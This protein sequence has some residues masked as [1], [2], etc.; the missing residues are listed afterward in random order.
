MF[1]VS[2]L[3]VLDSK[4]EVLDSKLEALDSNLDTR[5][6]RV[7]RI[8][9]RVESFE[10][11]GTVN[12]HLPGTVIQGLRAW[13][14][15]ANGPQLTTVPF[16]DKRCVHT[17]RQDRLLCSTLIIFSL[18]VPKQQEVYPNSSERTGDSR[19]SRLKDVLQ[20]PDGPKQG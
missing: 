4:L 13:Y 20:L 17:S 14:G 1:L 5:N 6:F 11:R 15:M 2:K 3:E 8:E 9:D 16:S 12:L 19:V 7:S 18:S 10:F